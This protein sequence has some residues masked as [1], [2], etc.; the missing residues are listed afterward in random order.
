M[1]NEKKFAAS[2]ANFT[3]YY[4]VESIQLEFQFSFRIIF[5]HHERNFKI[6]TAFKVKVL[7]E[8]TWSRVENIS[9]CGFENFVALHMFQV[10]TVPNTNVSCN[11]K[12]LQ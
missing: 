2:L 9:V 3:R 4:V 6:N 10:T 1:K 12:K 11:N 5:L 8:E 7:E